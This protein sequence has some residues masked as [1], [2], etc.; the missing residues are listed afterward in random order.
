VRGFLFA[1]RRPRRLAL[2]RWSAASG[3]VLPASF[4]ELRRDESHFA[5]TGRSL[6]LAADFVG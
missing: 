1:V 2:E 6:A 4:F 3:S 5:V